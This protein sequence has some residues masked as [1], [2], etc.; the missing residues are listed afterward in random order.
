MLGFQKQCLGYQ[1][2]TESKEWKEIN[3]NKRVYTL[4]SALD[5]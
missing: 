4:A 3:Q 5:L 1:K 2:E